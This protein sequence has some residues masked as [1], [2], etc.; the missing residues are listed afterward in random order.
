MNKNTNKLRDAQTVI[1]WNDDN[2]SI[3]ITASLLSINTTRYGRFF[4]CVYHNGRH[5]IVENFDHVRL[6]EE[7]YNE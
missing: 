6:I 7:E 5:W 2:S 1:A 4:L 3:T